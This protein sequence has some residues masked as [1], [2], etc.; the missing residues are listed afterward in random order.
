MDTTTCRGRLAGRVALISGVAN[1][2]GRAAAQMFIEQGASVFGVD[3]DEENGLG[4][5]G[6]LPAERFQFHTADVSITEEVDALASAALNRFGRVDILFNQAGKI[7]VK[8]LLEH[9]EQDY[10]YLMNNNVRS[11]F[12]MTK[13]ILPVMLRQGTGVIITTSSVSASTATPMEPVYCSSKAAVTQ[14]TKS[15]AVEFRDKGIRANVISPGF[16]RTNHGLFEIERMRQLNVPADE[17]DIRLLQGRMC[18]PEEIASVAIFLASDES[19][20]VNGADVLV[21]NTFTA[22]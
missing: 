1:G 13:A 17:E 6:I 18:E 16:V 5:A 11:V 15:V 12:L 21:D 10:D 19:S 7:L 9:S 20:F 3:V 2:C 14:F 8:P 22:I 4:L